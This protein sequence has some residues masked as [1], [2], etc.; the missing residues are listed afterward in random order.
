[1]KISWRKDI[2]TP[3]PNLSRIPDTCSVSQNSSPEF[4]GV[5]P[6]LVFDSVL[7]TNA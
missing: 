7:R 1:M 4:P 6:H 3:L 2:T 5:T